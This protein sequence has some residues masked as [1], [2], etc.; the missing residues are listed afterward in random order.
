MKA[1]FSRLKISRWMVMALVVIVLVVEAVNLV[2]MIESQ[3]RLIM[4]QEE[5]QL[6]SL[7][8]SFEEMIQAE[9]QSA[10]A[11]A[12]AYADIPAVQ[13]A[14]ARRDRQELT[15][16][17]HASYLSLDEEFGVPQSQF[18]LAPAVSFLRLHELEK[19]GDDLSSFR[20]TVLAANRDK[21]PIAGL[22][23][24]KG[25]YGIRGVE[26]V[27][28]NGEHIGSF[29]MAANF[30]QAF[31]EEF[32]SDY[33]S[34]VSVFL[35]EDQAKV[36]TFEQENAQ[37]DESPSQFTLYA[38]TLEEPLAVS[39]DTR[40]KVY[41]T[42][43]VEITRGK[44][45]GVAYAVITTT[46]RDYADDIVGIAE[47]NISRKEALAQIARGRN[48]VIFIG[49][50]ILVVVAGAGSIALNRALA[51]P[52]E[53]LTLV[54]QSIAT[55]DLSQQILISGRKDEIGLLAE[56]FKQMT[57]YLTNMTE[58]AQQIAGGDLT[59]HLAPAAEKD[60]LGHAL[61]QMLAQLKSLLARIGAHSRELSRSTNQLAQA[62]D[63]TSQATRQITDT[64]QMIAA[65]TEKQSSLMNQA[66]STVNQL[67][68]AVTDVAMGAQE[69]ATAVTRASSLTAQIN[70]VFMKIVENASAGTHSA[71][72]ATIT[73][74]TGANT[75]EQTIDSMEKIRSKV[76]FSTG[77][78][79]EMGHRSEQVSLIVE[80]IDGIAS[81][82]NL[83][84]LN[85]A[86]E[87]ARAGEHGKGFAVVA[88]EVR[89][90]AE[91]SAQATNE[92]RDLVLNIQHTVDDAVRAMKES[93]QE[94]EGGVERANASHKA[95][96]D[97]LSVS[98]RVVQ[99]VSEISQSAA[100][101][102]NTADE[103]VK[104]METVSAVVE[105]NTASTE[106][107][108]AGSKEISHSIENVAVLGQE[109][110]ATLHEVS[111]TTQEISAQV[112]SVTDSA[113]ALAQMA[114]ELHQIVSEFRLE[115]M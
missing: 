98:E 19:Y 83:L 65:S 43:V 115:E 40:L 110:S 38:S 7:A 74:R 64:I 114:Q 23:K 80:T 32:A 57:A 99:Q 72:E 44:S 37:V 93:A 24:G 102:E 35:R 87:A 16:L 5:D 52:I 70:Q 48:N 39:E 3:N 71:N 29:E 22:E 4:D 63:Q 104:S 112:A 77:K 62:A 92:I 46:I 10:L 49:L 101:I 25:G 17:L 68:N 2:V 13:A 47:I 95:L 86:I 96:A 60:V 75:V 28:Y 94:V 45:E 27:F 107:M 91:K 90:L 78:V 33:H 81:Q 8:I 69:Q 55:G 31:L 97:I 103:L 106:Q 36:E 20:S 105:E 41:D 85:A 84:A 61:A 53:H 100:G 66:S 108:S 26:P 34:Q 73:S 30:D 56:S 1:F 18:H 11:M 12:A 21:K 76:G 15:E 54:A 50:G 9:G 42:G 111:A 51:R 79:E 6:L 67:S 88:D 109:N 14:F 59:V 113:Q 82:I 58:V 89:K